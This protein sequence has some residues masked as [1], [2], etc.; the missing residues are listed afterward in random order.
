MASNINASGIDENYPVAGQDNDSQGF[1][2]NFNVIKNNLA[3]AYSE[4]TDLQNNTAKLNTLNDFNGEIIQNASFQQTSE[5]VYSIGAQ[6]GVVEISWPNGNYQTF[7]AIGDGT[8]NLKNWPTTGTVGKLRVV[9]FGPTAAVTHNVTF[10]PIGGA[11]KSNGN[12][13]PALTITTGETKIFDFWTADQGITVYA[14]YLGN[15]T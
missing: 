4:I 2:D 10:V 13:S 3:S 15:F 1:R 7:T 14:D 11:F 6:Q 5:E 12:F 8:Y 9:V